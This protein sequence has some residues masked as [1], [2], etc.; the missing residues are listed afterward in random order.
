MELKKENEDPCK[1]F[2]YLSIEVHDK[3]FT[4]ELLDKRDAFFHIND[5]PYLDRNISSKMC[6]TSICFEILHI[7]RTTTYLINTVNHANLL[8]I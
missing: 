5:M 8:R 3:K 6:Y 1:A 7:A 4:T 2:F